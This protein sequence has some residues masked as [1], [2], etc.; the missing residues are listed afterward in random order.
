MSYTSQPW[1][2]NS[3]EPKTLKAKR[4]EMQMKEISKKVEENLPVAVARVVKF[5]NE[6]KEQT[7]TNSQIAAATGVKS[8]SGIMDK[9][10]EIGVVKVVKIRKSLTSGISQVYQSYMGSLNKVEK[11]RAAEGAIAQIFGVFRKIHGTYTKEE[12]SEITG[13]SK[14][15][16]STALST[17]LVTE[18]I[19][20]IGIKENALVYQNIRGNK[21]AVNISTEPDSNY[22]TL[23]NYIKMNNIRSDSKEIKALVAKEKGHSRLFYSGK[24][25]VKEYEITYLQKVIGLGKKKNKKGLVEKIKIFSRAL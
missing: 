14:N 8:V 9:L 1:T 13:I 11:E 25:I 16:V 23:G 12:L 10:E 17:L 20:V 5:L 18:N 15:K 2:L 21:K 7:Y 6:N 22:M 24:G 4:E 19:K 3:K